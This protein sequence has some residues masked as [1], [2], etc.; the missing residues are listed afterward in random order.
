MIRSAVR[1]LA[2]V[3]AVPMLFA[4]C[5]DGSGLDL[6]GGA[7]GMDGGGVA[8]TF[9]P[10]LSIVDDPATTV[11]ATIVAATGGSITTTAAD[12]TVFTLT[13][14]AEA[15]EADTA[16][17]ATVAAQVGGI[18]G[19]GTVRAVHFEPAGLQFI[20]VASL[21]ITSTAPVADGRAFPFSSHSD[22]TEPQMVVLDAAATSANTVTIL[23]PHFSTYGFGELM[24]DIA[25]V[26]HGLSATPAYILQTEIAQLVETRRNLVR[27][28]RPTTE[29]DAVLQNAF[30]AYIDQVLTPLIEAGAASCDAAYEAALASSQYQDMWRRNSLPAS[31]V[32]LKTVANNAF[33]AM[34]KV[35]ETERIDECVDAKN[36]SILV[37][38]WKNMRKW[39]SRFGFDPKMGDDPSLYESRAK[40]IC[41]GY[42]YFI[43]GG[44]EDFQVSN[45]KVCDIRTSF[46]L[47]APGVGAAQ[48]SGGES[49]SGTYSA[50]GVFNFSYTGT[51]TI[52]LPNGPGEPGAMTASSGGQIAGQGGSGTE[53]YTLTPA[54]EACP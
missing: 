9:A 52:S 24:S 3:V 20:G 18:E 38:F 28:G 1:L 40:K 50:S 44:L 53:T 10:V 45:Q 25:D 31:I 46:V 2:S 34:E 29:I 41:N 27:E 43:T 8:V 11:S 12:G 17:T 6:P 5:S 7:D 30:N 21:S 39:R 33:L 48:F 22:G 54:F 19:V 15:L 49:L 13:V 32:S 14:P 26:V 4:A 51:Y 16:I 35:C 36:P 47:T 42:A 37:N 23:V